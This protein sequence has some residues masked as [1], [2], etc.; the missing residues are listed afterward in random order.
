M[1]PMNKQEFLDHA[2]LEVVTL[3][4]WLERE[5]IRPDRS[6]TDLAF[7]A[8]DAARARLIQALIRDFGVNDEGVTLILHLTDQLYSVRRVLAQVR[9]A[10]DT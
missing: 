6:A 1:T 7:T 5:W 4:V 2:G 10:Q 3:D 8:M 9:A